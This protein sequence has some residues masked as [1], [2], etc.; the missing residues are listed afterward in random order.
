VRIGSYINPSRLG[1]KVAVLI[2]KP[3]LE[4]GS[5][6]LLYTETPERIADCVVSSDKA[7]P[8]QTKAS[9]RKSCYTGIYTKM[10]DWVLGNGPR[11]TI[12]F[13]LDKGK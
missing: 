13:T 9:P 12:S 2:I 10:H 4:E 8:R 5:G 3:R 6:L 11:I 7:L 1:D